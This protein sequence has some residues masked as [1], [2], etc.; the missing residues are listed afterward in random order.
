VVSFPDI[1]DSFNHQH[2]LLHFLILVSER[3]PKKLDRAYSNKLTNAYYRKILLFKRRHSVEESVQHVRLKMS[4]IRKKKC[5][6]MLK[7]Q[8]SALVCELNMKFRFFSFFFFLRHIGYRFLSHWVSV[9]FNTESFS[10]SFFH[11]KSFIW[12]RE[13]SRKKQLIPNCWASQ[14]AFLIGY[15]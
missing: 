5:N 2:L 13:T 3:N 14:L 15:F 6:S 9:E 10:L 7:S 4:G 11:W 8:P 12:T 1:V